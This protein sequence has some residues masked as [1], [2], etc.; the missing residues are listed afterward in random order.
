MACAGS[1]RRSRWPITQQAEQLAPLAAYRVIEA[2][3]DVRRVTTVG[4]QE[5]TASQLAT[6]LGFTGGRQQT[7]VGDL[8]GGERRR[9]QLLRLL[10]TEPNVIL[11]DEPTNDLDV[12]TLTSLEDVLD[13]WAGTLVVVS[14]DRYLLERVTDRQVG[15]LGD[16]RVQ[17]LPGGV[18]Q[19]LRMR[20][21]QREHAAAPPG[22]V[23]PRAGPGPSDG[24]TAQQARAARRT[25][26]RVEKALARVADREARVHARMA[27]V[28]AD[29][30]AVIALDGQLRAL[31]LER[32]A[33]ESA[34]LDAAQVLD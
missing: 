4:R 22:P 15:L 32:E 2:V 18:E 5:V 14:H 8:S 33:L 19:Y 6:R 26:A 13:G 9:L 28:A 25:I 29:H 3:E 21:A 24:P 34:W 30:A 7:L 31:V 10:M 23:A 17:D 11:L 12:P 1:A 20:R 16:G 27:A